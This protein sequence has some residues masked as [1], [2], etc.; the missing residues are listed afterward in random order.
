VGRGK[1]SGDEIYHYHNVNSK[2][3]N[4]IISDLVELRDKKPSVAA[5][6]EQ[7]HQKR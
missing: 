5:K 2:E 4:S 1:K 3:L 6:H 7:K